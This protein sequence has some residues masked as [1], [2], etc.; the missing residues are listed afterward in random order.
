MS[1]FGLIIRVQDEQMNYSKDK[2]KTFYNNCKKY[3]WLYT[4]IFNYYQYTLVIS[5]IIKIFEEDLPSI[6]I[7]KN[8]KDK[9]LTFCGGWFAENWIE[10]VSKLHSCLKE[11]IMDEDLYYKLDKLFN[12]MKDIHE[13]SVSCGFIPRKVN[14][15]MNTKLLT[16]LHSIRIAKI[17]VKHANDKFKGDTQKAMMDYYKIPSNRGSFDIREF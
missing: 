10:L 2:I 1:Y 6:H 11:N 9:P 3:N 5:E 16:L 15:H 8:S 13:R 7:L 4:P 17:F 12:D 14:G